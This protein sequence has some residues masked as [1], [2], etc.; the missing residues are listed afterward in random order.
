[1]QGQYSSA[2]RGRRQIWFACKTNCKS[3]NKYDAILLIHIIG[4]SFVVGKYNLRIF[5]PQGSKESSPK[6]GKS[7]YL[8]RA[9][10]DSHDLWRR[11]HGLNVIL[12]E[13]ISIIV[14]KHMGIKICCQFKKGS[15]KVIQ[16]KSTGHCYGL[17]VHYMVC[18]NQSMERWSFSLYHNL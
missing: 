10:G 3:N 13:S 8:L 15:K 11:S 1:M 18:T 4:R 5:F 2:E 14:F 12:D 17:N 6:S 9:L 7:F 16:N